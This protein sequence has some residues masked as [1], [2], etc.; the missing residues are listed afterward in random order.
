LCLIYCLNISLIDI[1]TIKPIKYNLKNVREYCF[2]S[3]KNYGKSM[4]SDNFLYR[5]LE[6]ALNDYPPSSLNALGQKL[7]YA[8]GEQLK[9]R[10]PELSK[11]ISERYVNYKKEKSIEKDKEIKEKII[12]TI[13]ESFKN[14]IHPAQHHVANIIGIT[15]LFMDRKYYIIWKMEANKK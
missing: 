3:K 1:I 14:G 8:R 7:G 13:N 11:K 2:S 6:K 15:G 12:S 9:R 4:Y 10:Q 5:E